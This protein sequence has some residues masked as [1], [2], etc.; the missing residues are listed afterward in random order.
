MTKFSVIQN[1]K[2]QSF[3][4]IPNVPFV[5]FERALMMLPQNKFNDR[6]FRQHQAWEIIVTTKLNIVRDLEDNI[7]C[8]LTFADFIET[9][10]DV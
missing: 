6:P 4:V 8:V 2:T 9:I 1:N 5:R 3:N 10:D 7:N